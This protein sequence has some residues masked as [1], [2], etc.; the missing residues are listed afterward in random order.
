V[1][2]EYSQKYFKPIERYRNVEFERDW[3]LGTTSIEED[4]HMGSLQTTLVKPSLYALTYNLRSFNKGSSYHGLMNNASGNLK[5]S[6]FTFLAA[7]SYLNSKGLNSKTNFLRHNADISRPVWK[8][9]LGV[10]E[11]S[12]NNKFYNLITDSLVPGSYSFNEIQG[13]IHTIDSSKTRVGLSYKKRIDRTPSQE[14]FKTSSEADESS[15]I[16]EFTRNPDNTLRTTTTY[17]NLVLKD[18]VIN[19][20]DAGK[21]LVNR[22]DHILNLWKGILSFNTYYEVGSGQERKQEYYYCRLQRAREFI[23]GKTSTTME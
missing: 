10:S 20:Q 2:Y 13:Y 18:S 17:R 4:E 16:M 19:Q 6:D 1:N 15:L 3:N 21:T 12:E 9:I 11:N 7:G 5:W 22:I 8:M 23:I 14:D